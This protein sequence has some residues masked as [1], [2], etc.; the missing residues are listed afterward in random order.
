V[1]NSGQTRRA[2]VITL[3]ILLVVV[4]GCSRRT[5]APPPPPAGWPASLE[6]F[7]MVWSADRG[8]DL[9]TAPATAVRA[10]TESY[11]LAKLAGDDKYLYPGFAQSVDQKSDLWPQ[12]D[13][14]AKTPWVGTAQAHIVSVTGAGPEV[15]AKVCMYLYGAGVLQYAGQYSAL[16]GAPGE[17]YP[18]IYPMQIV[19]AAPADG[20]GG[21][22]LQPQSGPA[23]TPHNDVFSGWRIT[24]QHGN[25]FTATG[26]S[27]A[28][29]DLCAAKAPDPPERRNALATGYHPRDDF[30]TRPSYPGWPTNAQ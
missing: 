16:V 5:V 1:R 24:S 12:T 18:G 23:R 6:Q 21:Q 8:I 2:V 13:A 22:V 30:P 10:Y 26:R 28:D 14:P 3:S 17:P 20:Q 15:I 4:G 19:M 7:T 25:Y 11:Y 9:T 29:L 27:Q